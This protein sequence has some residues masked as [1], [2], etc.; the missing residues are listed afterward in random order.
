MLVSNERKTLESSQ[1]EPVLAKVP[2]I[3]QMDLKATKGR[4]TRRSSY[5]SSSSKQSDLTDLTDSTMHASNRSKILTSEFSDQS[6]PEHIPH[7]TLENLEVKPSSQ[8]QPFQRSV[9]IKRPESLSNHPMAKEIQISVNKGSDDN[10][11]VAGNSVISGRSILREGK[12]STLSTKKRND[13]ADNN[14]SR[15][16]TKSSKKTLPTQNNLNPLHSRAKE[17]IEEDR[18][19][20][21]PTVHR[22]NNFRTKPGN[23]IRRDTSSRPIIDIDS[24]RSKLSDSVTGNILQLETS[25]HNGDVS[26][27]RIHSDSLINSSRT[28]ASMLAENSREQ[29]DTKPNDQDT[30]VK[31][32][33]LQDTN[34]HSQG[35]YSDHEYFT[36]EL[37]QQEVY[38]KRQLDLTIHAQSTL[39]SHKGS[40]SFDGNKSAPNLGSTD[41]LVN[42]EMNKAQHQLS[43]EENQK[44]L[45]ENYQSHILHL[46]GHR[47]QNFS[48][49][50]ADKE[51]TNT[52]QLIQQE[53]Y[54]RIES[55]PAVYAKINRMRK[56]DTAPFSGHNS[57]PN[58]KLEDFQLKTEARGAHHQV[59]KRDRLP[60]I[61]PQTNPQSFTS[62]QDI[63]IQRVNNNNSDC[64]ER[65]RV[66]AV[67][68]H[69]Q[70]PS[71][72]ESTMLN[73]PQFVA[74]RQKSSKSFPNLKLP[75]QQSVSN[76]SLSVTDI[77]SLPNLQA[78]RQNSFHNSR[79]TDNDM[80]SLSRPLSPNQQI[81]QKQQGQLLR[82]SQNSDSAPKVTR[83]VTHLGRRSSSKKA[84]AVSDQY[85]RTRNLPH[86]QQMVDNQ[87]RL[88][89]PTFEL[90]IMHQKE[91]AIPMHEENIKHVY[92]S[93]REQNYSHHQQALPAKYKTS[94]DTQMLPRRPGYDTQRIQNGDLQQRQQHHRDYQKAQ[95][96]PQEQ[97]VAFLTAPKT[98]VKQ[99]SSLQKFFGGARNK[100]KQPP[101]AAQH[102]ENTQSLQPDL[103]EVYNQRLAMAQSAFDA[104][105]QR[106][107]II[108]N[109]E[110]L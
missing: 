51:I 92:A 59:P 69:S 19:M 65:Q 42:L 67:E 80:K 7:K 36:N 1:E 71:R 106:D 79:L 33:I 40:V 60:I 5:D 99:R 26:P 16:S 41:F 72:L 24:A 18:F 35:R 28:F 82:S 31:D 77:A 38:T 54:T 29:H 61:S 47:H 101:P 86:R 100:P 11:S 102:D 22:R 43:S 90:T 73:N 14:S 70:L 76:R 78:Q 8:S 56:N 4:H 68:A 21:D 30:A 81:P 64:I 57:L 25:N 104:I 88:G 23:K 109:W 45:V 97:N 39:A 83:P 110:R 94:Q 98:P 75:K 50:C 89:S 52:A 103:Q 13:A 95:Q 6:G 53:E 74:R 44:E 107:E 37:L 10:Q 2:S 63:V 9:S 91:V 84:Q 32:S 108:P 96:Q 20:S 48:S 12:Y 3:N 93:E 58:L 85:A 62:N 87:Q 15:A 66:H 17:I 105:N 34:P 46:R 49:T 27:S 55:D